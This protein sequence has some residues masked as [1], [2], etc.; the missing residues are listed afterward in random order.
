MQTRP[1]EKDQIKKIIKGTKPFIYGKLR[2]MTSMIADF[3]QLRETVMDIEE[4][5]AENKK[6]YNLNRRAVG[7]SSGTKPITAEVT[8]IKNRRFSNLGRPLSKV[9]EKLVRQRL[10]KPLET[11]PLPNPPPSNLDM[12]RYCRFHQQHG[13]DTDNCTRLRHEI[14][15]LIHSR[16]IPDPEK[17]QPNTHRNP[18]PIITQFLHLPT[19]KFWTIRKPCPRNP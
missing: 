2:R 5:E 9:L 19:D 4:E 14:Q 16:K 8:A 12:N 7:G 17:E 13:H 10:L 11:K 1:S 3:R 6:F 15:N 18:Y